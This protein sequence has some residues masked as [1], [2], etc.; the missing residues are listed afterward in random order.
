M[1]YDKTGGGVGGRERERGAYLYWY[2]AF[3]DIFDKW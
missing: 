2:E 3:Q 1:E